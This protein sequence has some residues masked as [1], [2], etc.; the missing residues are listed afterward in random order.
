VATPPAVPAATAADLLL[1]LYG[2]VAIDTAAVDPEL[3]GA[4]RALTDTD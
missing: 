4:F 3:L 2:R 1:W